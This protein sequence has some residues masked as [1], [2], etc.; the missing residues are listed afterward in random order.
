LRVLVDTSFAARGP[1]GT[2]VYVEHVV[3][4][5][6]ERGEV[7]VV[8][9]RQPLRLRP[10]REGRRWNPVRSVANAAL[11]LAWL[12][13]GLP[14]AA[15]RA[16]AAVLHHPLPARSIL[17]RTPQVVTVLGA[18]RGRIV[19]APHGPGQE[20]PPLE[21]RAAPGHLLY[22]GDGEPRKNLDGLLAAY[23]A[24][25]RN[26]TDALPLVLAG[27]AAARASGNG[28]RGEP[29]PDAPRL[30]ELHAAAAALVH[31]S[32]HEGFGLTL[33][34]AM[35]AGTPVVAVRNP[36]TEEVCGDAALLVEPEGLAAALDRVHGDA[37]LRERLAAAGRDRAA[38][39][40]WDACAALHERAY[41][42]AA[43][44]H[45]TGAST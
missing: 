19:V 34:E 31:P 23:D 3:A 8:E 33:A 22:V 42:L 13:L 41:K 20:L 10:G 27:A 28:V 40:S 4:A 44:T 6:R 5:L 29:G 15:R 36:G 25:R 30:A 21:R 35:R 17:C 12:H 2:G 39:L 37:G 26:V 18:D 24:H 14:L 9:A 11:D 7:E 43:A 1:S 38:L 45:R 16:R 32:L